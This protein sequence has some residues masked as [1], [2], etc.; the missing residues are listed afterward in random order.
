MRIFNRAAARGISEAYDEKAITDGFLEEVR[1][2]NEVFAAFRTHS[3]QNAIARQMTDDKGR[4]KS[5]GQFRKDVEPLT[6]K[7]CDQWLNTEYNTAIIRAHRAADWKHFEAEKDVYPNLRWMPTTS[8]NPDPVHARFWT[9]KLT[10]PVDDPFWDHHHPGERWGCKCTC[11]QTDEPV[12]DLGV[13]EDKTETASRGLKGNPGVTGKLF[14][15]DHPYF[16]KDCGNCQFNKNFRN[17]LDGFFNIKRDCATCQACLNVIESIRS[18]KFPSEEEKKAS[19]EKTEVFK[20]SIPEGKGLIVPIKNVEHLNK[21]TISRA[22]VKCWR[23]HPH[24]YLVAKNEAITDMRKL[25]ARAEYYGWAEDDTVIGPNGSISKKHPEL[26]YWKYFKV[27]IYDEESFIC[28]QV[29]KNGMNVP[30]C[31]NDQITWAKISQK[32]RQEKPPK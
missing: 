14:S 7:Y 15:E 4:L 22:A 13:T 28:V 29:R 11:E 32:V 12:N 17:R 2:N 9:Q 3:M 16:P 27:Q 31:I 6:G 24:K 5:F 19:L 25:F 20:K 23:S 21:L 8:A 10:L 18:N 1:H 30:Y 26:K